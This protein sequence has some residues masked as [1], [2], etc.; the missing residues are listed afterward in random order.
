[1]YLQSLKGEKHAIVMYSNSYKVI[2]PRS[3]GRLVFYICEK[4]R[5][6]IVIALSMR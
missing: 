3:G 6:L 4:L 5:V 1:M 2:D